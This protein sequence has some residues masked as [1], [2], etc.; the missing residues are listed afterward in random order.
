MTTH[1]RRVLGE[2]AFV[3]PVRPVSIALLL[4]SEHLNGH[5]V[6]VALAGQE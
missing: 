2:R 1:P 5:A 6:W 4:L 3:T